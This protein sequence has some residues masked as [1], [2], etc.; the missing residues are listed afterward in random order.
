MKTKIVLGLL[1]GVAIYSTVKYQKIKSSIKKLNIKISRIKSLKVTWDK[2][3]FDLTFSIHNQTAQSI[4]VNSYKLLKLTQIEFYSKANHSF[5]GT[6]NMNITNIQIP[7]NGVIEIKDVPT[8]LPLQ[9][10]L[11][12]LELFKENIQENLIIKLQFESLGK[13]FELIA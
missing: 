12:N 8:S 1:T 3:E 9:N 10:L 13:Q 7:A 11:S 2:I 5:L 4:G 6:S